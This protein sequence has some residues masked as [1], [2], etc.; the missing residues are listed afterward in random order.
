MTGSPH[1]SQDDLALYALQALS[2]EELVALRE[3][4]Y[5]CDVCQTE[6]AQLRGDLAMVALSVDQYPL[7][8]GARE[9]FAR[10]IKLHRDP[11]TT[12]TNERT[13]TDR[14][15]RFGVTG[16]IGWVAAAVILVVAGVLSFE[17]RILK[18]QLH[19]ENARL[20]ELEASKS[21]AQHVV[22]LLTSPTAQ[23]ILLTAPQTLPK[24]TGR[25]VYLPSRGELILQANNLAAVPTGKVY[26]LWLIPADGSAPMPAGLF[27]P[28]AAGNG[29]VVL[30]N[31]PSGVTAKAF[32][33][34]LEDAAGSKTPTAPIL[35]AGAVP[36]N[37]I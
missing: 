21:R 29:S 35:L 23:R 37:G 26:E 18:T 20:A 1:I 36:A 13:A 22:D 4:L 5:T 16:W 12:E 8:P 25:V 24:P 2:P 3:H 27:R 15:F 28:D 19:D 34:T 6:L 33:I 14:A 11:E 32:G 17:V 7:P 31:I 10:R 9:R 30:P